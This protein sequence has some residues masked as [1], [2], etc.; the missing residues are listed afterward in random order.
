MTAS[1]MQP[2]MPGTNFLPRPGAPVQSPPEPGQSSV[3]D[4]ADC[5]VYSANIARV[6]LDRKSF[7]FMR[8]YP[9]NIP[10]SEKGVRA[11]GAALGPFQFDRVYSHFFDLVMPRGAKRILEEPI[12][13][14]VAAIGGAYDRAWL[15]ATDFGLFRVPPQSASSIPR[16]IPKRIITRTTFS[17][18][19]GSRPVLHIRL[20]LLLDPISV[21]LN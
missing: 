19:Q 18:S 17:R 5:V 8:S 12:E 2:A 11:I 6:N 14:Y 15:A 7:T 16:K 4:Y 21:G 13:R 1:S 9:N 10:L 20:F 3:N